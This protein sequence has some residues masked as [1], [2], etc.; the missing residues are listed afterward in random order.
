MYEA[1]RNKE[2]HWKDKWPWKF[3]GDYYI[4]SFQKKE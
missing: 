1:L 3:I 2:D 4:I